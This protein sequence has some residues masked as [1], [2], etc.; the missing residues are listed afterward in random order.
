MIPSHLN[1]FLGV[2]SHKKRCVTPI[3][4]ATLRLRTPAVENPIITSGAVKSQ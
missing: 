1:S 4:V 2:E 3:P